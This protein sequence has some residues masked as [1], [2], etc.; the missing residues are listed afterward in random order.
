MKTTR[1][2]SCP[3]RDRRKRYVGPLELVTPAPRVSQHPG[4]GVKPVRDRP[5][6][7][8]APP[9]VSAPGGWVVPTGP[10][11]VPG[12]SIFCLVQLL[13]RLLF[14]LFHKFTQVEIDIVCH[15]FQKKTFTH[16]FFVTS[17]WRCHFGPPHPTPFGTPFFFSVP[18]FL[19]PCLL[20][21]PEL[22][23]QRHVQ[24][25]VCGKPSQTYRRKKITKLFPTPPIPASIEGSFVSPF[26]MDN[27]IGPN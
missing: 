23:G 26:P 2:T 5:L 10:S 19:Q 8:A 17:P 14:A 22:H 15:L 12:T 27:T 4:V 20:S 25:P 6:S 11:C 16:Q 9:Q 1:P 13:S 18:T 24:P 21:L 3:T 7:P